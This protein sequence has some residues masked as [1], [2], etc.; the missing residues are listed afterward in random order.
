MNESASANF[1]LL[2]A[3]LIPGAT[4]LWG[5][6]LF[7]PQLAALFTTTTVNAPTIGGFLYLTIASLAAGMAVSALRWAILDTLHAC[8]RLTMPYLDF[9]KLGQNVEGFKLLIEIHYRHY[10][11]YGNECVAV[12]LAYICYRVHVGL[13][14]AWGWWDIGV[15]VLEVIF[16]AAS[17]DT[18]KKYLT[19]GEQLLSKSRAST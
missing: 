14:G 13:S 16:V 3:Y 15:L 10:L 6:S 2:I 17:R 11:H 4:L 19:R 8:T 7:S 18:L 9:S 12:A 1:G 5:L